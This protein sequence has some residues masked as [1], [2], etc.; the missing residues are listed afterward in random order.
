MKKPCACTAICILALALPGCG[1][2]T[3]FDIPEHLKTF[4]VNTFRNKTLERNLD[5][6]FTEAL[7]HEVLA[8]TSLRVARPGEADLEIDGEIEGFQRHSLRRRRY[9]EKMEVRHLL[10]VN[11]EMR[12]TRKNELFFQGRRIVERAEFSLNLGE[13]PREGRDALVRGLA[14]RVVALAFEHWPLGPQ[15]AQ[16]SGQ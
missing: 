9:D 16:A 13:T 4:S 8:R 14:R 1:Y 10:T 11:V 6:E 2:R 12:D 3:K 7:I 5:F 15:E